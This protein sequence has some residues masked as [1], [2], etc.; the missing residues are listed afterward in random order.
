MAMKTFHVSRVAEYG[1]THIE[2]RKPG[3]EP[4]AGKQVSGYWSDARF[5]GML[6]TMLRTGE[7]TLVVGR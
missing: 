2:V 5:K 3:Q 7:V 4:G 1:Y 6:R